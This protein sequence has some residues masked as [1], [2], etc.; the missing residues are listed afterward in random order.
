MILAINVYNLAYT[1]VFLLTFLIS[2]LLII[3]TRL[4]NLFKQGRV[5]EIRV[6]QVMLALIFAYL[7]TQGIM[8]LVNATQF[9]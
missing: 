6:A 5:W 9:A 4:E 3:Q 2:Y 8:S 1:I 7:L